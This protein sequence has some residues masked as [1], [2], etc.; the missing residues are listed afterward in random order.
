MSASQTLYEVKVSSTSVHRELQKCVLCVS[1]VF[2][3]IISSQIQLAKI[4]FLWR[5]YGS[6]FRERVR[7]LVILEWLKVESL[8]LCIERSQLRWF[9]HLVMMS[10]GCFPGYL[11]HICSTRSVEASEQTQD[12]LVRLCCSA[13]LR[14]FWCSPGRAGW[15][16]WEEGRLGIYARDCWMEQMVGLDT[17]YVTDVFIPNGNKELSYKYVTII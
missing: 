5:V 1:C 11:M 13:V 14:A 15:C 6:T 3:F 7:T 4:N 8:L 16:S 9:G 17:D 12:S 10:A 2:S